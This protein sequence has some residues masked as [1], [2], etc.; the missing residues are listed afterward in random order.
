MDDDDECMRDNWF[1]KIWHFYQQI[2]HLN[3]LSDFSIY[4]FL[5]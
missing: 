5:G 3:I 2:A 1:E 4:I